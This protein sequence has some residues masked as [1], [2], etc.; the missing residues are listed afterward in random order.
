MDGPVWRV[1]LVALV[2]SL[3][4][5]LVFW[6]VGLAGSSDARFDGTLLSFA[7]GTTIAFSMWLS[8][9]YLN[10]W[11]ARKI[12]WLGKPWLSFAKALLANVIVAVLTLAVIYFAVF[13]VFGDEQPLMWIRRQRIGQYIGSVLIGL[14]ITAIYQGANFIKLWKKSVH[15]AEQLSSANLSAKYETLN[16]Q[17]NPHFLFNSLNVLSS[18]VRTDP[19]RAEVFIEGLSNVYRYVLEVRQESTVPLMRELEAARAYSKLIETRFGSER[20]RFSFEIEPSEQERIVPL[21]LQMLIENAVKHNGATKRNPLHID[22]G[23][24]DEH[25]FVRNNRVALFEEPTGNNIGLANISERYEL[26]GGDSITV[27]DSETYYTV[28][29]PKLYA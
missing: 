2:G 28:L 1:V 12:D 3:I 15:Q 5:N 10:T 9:G 23:E 21:A 18:L 4:I 25:Y 26:I 22:V 24:R 16:A 17:V 20:I 14:L 29:L 8:M 19:G 6:L 13:V 11:L 27:E 7:L